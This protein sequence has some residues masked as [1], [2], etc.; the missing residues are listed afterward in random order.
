MGRGIISKKIDKDKIYMMILGV[1]V[2]SCIWEMESNNSVNNS[3]DIY[4]R[5]YVS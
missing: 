2:G 4:V 1:G 3:L 5:L